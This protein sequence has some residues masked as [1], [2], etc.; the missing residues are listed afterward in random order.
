MDARLNYFASP[1]AGKAFKYF[2]SAGRELKESPLPATHRMICREVP[3]R[4]A[5]EHVTEVDHA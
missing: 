4:I 2:M 1:T 5:G 3:R